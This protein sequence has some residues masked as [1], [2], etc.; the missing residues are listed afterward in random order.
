MKLG[1]RTTQTLLI[2]GAIAAAVWY[3]RRNASALNPADSDNVVNQG[4]N[5][6]VREASGDDSQ[7]LGG[8]I[9]DFFNPD[10]AG[11]TVFRREDMNQ[12]RTPGINPALADPSEYLQG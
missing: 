8:A 5:A 12:W 7:T 1:D 3:L 6:I 4:V 2:L 10:A 11:R 9:F